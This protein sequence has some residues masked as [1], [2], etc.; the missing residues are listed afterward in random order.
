MLW[1]EYT[2]IRAAEPTF[3]PLKPRFS[4]TS[5]ILAFRRCARQYGFFGVRG[6]VPAHTVQLFYGTI[7]HEVLDRAH[8]HYGGFDDKAT[9]GTIPSDRDIDGYFDEVEASLKAR[10][11]RSINRDLSER[12]RVV[13]KRFNSLEGPR[14]YPRVIDT[15]C[16]VQGDRPTHIVEGVIDVLLS[17]KSSSPNPSEVEIWDYKGSK[18]P[19]DPNDPKDQYARET[20]RYQML[21]YSALYRMKYGVLPKRAVLY[22]MNELD[23]DGLTSTPANAIWEINLTGV[24]IDTALTEFDRTAAEII[25]CAERQTWNPPNPDQIPEETCAACDIRWSCPSFGKTVGTKDPPRLRM[26]ESK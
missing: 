23:R 17:A 14:L 6:F 24:N 26:R 1:K 11:I 18:F 22:F 16:K 9:R 19:E 8:R 20:Y 4:L 15:E 3:V 2:G 25:D 21:V 5:D 10:G 13:L 7:I 12:A